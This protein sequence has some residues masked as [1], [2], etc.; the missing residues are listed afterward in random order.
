MNAYKK[1]LIVLFG[2]IVIALIVVITVRVFSKPQA[3]SPVV[4]VPDT[5][6]IVTNPAL[7]SLYTMIPCQVATGITLDPQ[8]GALISKKTT[9][10]AEYDIGL[11]NGAQVPQPAV[12][13]VADVIS[14]GLCEFEKSYND[15]VLSIEDQ[16]MLGFTDDINNRYTYTVSMKQIPVNRW[17]ITNFLV[18]SYEFTGGAHGIGAISNV[19]FDSKNN[20]IVS[21]AELF[22]SA[23]I[24][25]LRMLVIKKLQTTLGDM[26]DID[27]MNDGVNDPKT[28][29]EIVIPTET[30]LILKFQSYSVAPYAAGQPE[31]EFTFNELIPLLSPVWKDQLGL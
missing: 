4:S 25:K 21:G 19:L 31:I 12:Q 28:L 23:R 11:D 14:S 2:L 15:T 24:S 5:T 27:M 26:A 30:G 9:K 13:T 1:S 29:L 22:D 8:S 20:R 17:G 16:K 18:D 3:T 7:V 6:P 10:F